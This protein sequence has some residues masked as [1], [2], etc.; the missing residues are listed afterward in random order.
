L[1]REGES[2]K[3]EETGGVNKE[4]KEEEKTGDEKEN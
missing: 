2:K 1:K 4:G 3:D